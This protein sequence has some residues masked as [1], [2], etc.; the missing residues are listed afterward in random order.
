[1]QKLVDKLFPLLERNLGFIKTLVIFL[2]GYAT[3]LL[4]TYDRSFRV[5]QETLSRVLRWNNREG[6]FCSQVHVGHDGTTLWFKSI[7]QEVGTAG[8]IDPFSLSIP[9]DLFLSQDSYFWL[10]IVLILVNLVIIFF[11]FFFSIRWNRWKRGDKNS[12]KNIE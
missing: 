5:H 11:L 10:L 9:Q 12:I 3:F 6:L 8:S 1:M 4:Y 2:F 7:P